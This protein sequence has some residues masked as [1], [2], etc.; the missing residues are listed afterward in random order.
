MTRFQIKPPANAAL[1]NTPPLWW[2]LGLGLGLTSTTRRTYALTH[3]LAPQG[4]ET[5]RNQSVCMKT[6]ASHKRPIN[7][8]CFLLHPSDD[9]YVCRISLAGGGEGGGK[10]GNGNLELGI[11][12]SK[13]GRERMCVFVCVCVSGGC[14]VWVERFIRTK[15]KHISHHSRQE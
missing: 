1:S 7:K 15:F 3:T 12:L 5:S 9:E 14:G 4:G 2:G 6:H 8:A 11:Y 13:S 10:R